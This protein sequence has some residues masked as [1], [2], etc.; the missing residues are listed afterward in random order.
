MDSVRHISFSSRRSVLV[1]YYTAGVDSVVP[2]HGRIE[3][4]VECTSAKSVNEE[5]SGC[6]RRT[7]GHTER[8]KIVNIDLDI[9]ATFRI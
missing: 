1:P 2:S 5:A 6:C 9:V 8:V 3:N 4:E 7:A